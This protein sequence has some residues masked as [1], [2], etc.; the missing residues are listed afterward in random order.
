MFMWRE[1]HS[2]TAQLVISQPTLTRVIHQRIITRAAIFLSQMSATK[3][4]CSL[5]YNYCSCCKGNHFVVGCPNFQIV[6]TDQRYH[7]ATSQV[8]C[9]NCLGMYQ[10]EVCRSTFNAVQPSFLEKTVSSEYST[11][12]S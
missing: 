2:N 5:K 8:L 10:V 12:P 6:D 9:I 4:Q 7:L 3:R 1:H 11:R